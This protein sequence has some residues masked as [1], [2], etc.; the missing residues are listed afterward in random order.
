MRVQSAKNKGRKLQQQVCL[1]ILG[2]FE[3]LVGG[4][5]RSTSMGANGE[6]ILLSP[7]GRRVF[8][9]DVECKNCERLN[10]WSAIDQSER[11]A[12]T[13]GSGLVI[14]KKN[15][16]DAYVALPWS[17]FLSLHN[18]PGSG[19]VDIDDELGCVS[20]MEA[21]RGEL[22][23]V[24]LRIEKIIDSLGVGGDPGLVV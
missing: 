20:D 8:P 9:Y 12:N 3:C 13:P 1:D 6:D 21:V 23:A 22:R 2:H 5:V 14:F 15:R 11:N 4:D 16:R 19:D 18:C 24:G 10:I 7:L 17:V